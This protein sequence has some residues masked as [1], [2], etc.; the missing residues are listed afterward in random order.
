MHQPTQRQNI[1]STAFITRFL[2][3]HFQNRSKLYISFMFI[4]Y[5]LTF[6]CF[7]WTVE[8]FIK[9]FQNVNTR[10]NTHADA[11]SGFRTGKN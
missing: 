5:L 2:N 1:E 9:T 7:V 3:S 11:S 8:A 6:V 4:L 10:N